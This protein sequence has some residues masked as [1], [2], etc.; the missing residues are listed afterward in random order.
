MNRL[1]NIRYP[2][3]AFCGIC[4]GILS[5]VGILYSLILPFVIICIV[6]AVGV[7]VAIF[8]RKFIKPIVTIAVAFILGVSS[9]SIFN[10]IS[11][12]KRIYEDKLLVFEGY[13]SD[14]TVAYDNY[15][16]VVAR[17]VTATFPDGEKEKL[18]G[19]VSFRY[20]TDES[21][22]VAVGNSVVFRGKIHNNYIF[23][24]T[25]STYGARSGIDYTVTQVGGVAFYGGEMTFDEICRNYIR[26]V[27]DEYMPETSDLAYALVLGNKNAV[28]IDIIEDFQNAG[29]VHVLAVSGLHVGFI[30]SVFIFILD[31][32]KIKNI[33]KLPIVVLPLLFYAY[34]CGFVPSVMRALIMT[35]VSLLSRV[36]HG[37]A[38]MLNSI[39]VAGIVILLFSPVYL[40]DAGFLLSF[41]AVYGIATVSSSLNRKINS[42]IHNIYVAKLLR[43]MSVSL[44]ATVGTICQVSYFYGKLA[45]F[46]LLLNVIV[47]P[48]ISVVFVMTVLGLLP[49]VFHYAAWLADKIL[50]SIRIFAALVSSASFAT[51]VLPALTSAL[52]VIIV[53]MYVFGGF[54]NLK[55]KKKAVAN[56]VLAV[57][58]AICFVVSVV[59]LSQNESICILETYS[60]V[61]II[62]TDGENN[63]HLISNC[64]DMELCRDIVAKLSRHKV[65]SLKL[66]CYD[67]SEISINGLDYI[68]QEYKIDKLYRV[69]FKGNDVVDN[70]LNANNVDII[71][72]PPNMAVGSAVKVTN[73]NDGVP[74]AMSV[75]VGKITFTVITTDKIALA[76]NLAAVTKIGDVVYSPFVNVFER[77]DWECIKI[78][79]E[80]TSDSKL[81]STT[82][83]GNFT[84]TEKRGKISINNRG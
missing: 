32:F 24:D 7:F 51:M 6:I 74:I 21:D 47:I 46:G 76:D 60:D 30:S 44:G 56:I 1:L 81:Y 50:L 29:I 70:Y 39:S 78:I 59:P 36:L 62:V 57:V 19:K 53:C 18:R 84:I 68:Y 45:V 72:I 55:G 61:C 41:G 66:Y 10:C 22:E 9:L 25:V 43:M 31:K 34:I 8:K 79:A 64:S 40:F 11:V 83:C 71:D 12:S 65:C 82:K 73:I 16:L 3:I 38:D 23:K 69:N 48:L 28:D 2:L 14:G 54:V 13:V 33:L 49:W 75:E 5:A 63:F 80:E 26:N 37:R 67:Y 42:K 27:F 20:Y 52:A 4:L 58:L 15:V 77:V 17:D 35:M